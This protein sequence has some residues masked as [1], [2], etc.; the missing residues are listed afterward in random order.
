MP[1]NDL[2][3]WWIDGIEEHE[4][5]G[6]LPYKPPVFSDGVVVPPVVHTLKEKYGI[7]VTICNVN[8][9]SDY[10]QIIVDGAHAARI[11]RQRHMDG[12]NEYLI[13]SSAFETIVKSEITVE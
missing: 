13:S 4:E 8:P 1:K 5:H 11:V 3:R 10:W 6:L 7:N 9:Q 2:P 12:Q